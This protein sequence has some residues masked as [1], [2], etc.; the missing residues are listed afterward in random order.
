MA[1][2]KLYAINIGGSRYDNSFITKKTHLNF[3]GTN[4]ITLPLTLDSD[5]AMKVAFTTNS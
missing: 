1:N 2:V 5:Y 4:Y 3:T